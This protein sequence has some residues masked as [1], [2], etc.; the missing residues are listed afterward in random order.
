MLAFIL[1]NGGFR[2]AQRGVVSSVC[3]TTYWKTVLIACQSSLL[4]QASAGFLV[5]CSWSRVTLECW[6]VSCMRMSRFTKM[7]FPSSFEACE[8]RKP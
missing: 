2:T 1:L 8:P 6:N 3:Q 7:V 5:G 4:Y